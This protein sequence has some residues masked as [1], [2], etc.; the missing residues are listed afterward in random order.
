[1]KL[2]VESVSISVE[3]D[4]PSGRALPVIMINMGGKERKAFDMTVQNWSSMVMYFPIIRKNF[5]YYFSQLQATAYT[6]MMV[7]YYSIVRDCWE[8]ILEPVMDPKDDEAPPVMWFMN[9]SVSK[10]VIKQ[11]VCFTE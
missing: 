2:L 7:S 1:M 6:S 4:M 3:Q 5:K 8:P 11:L 9:I 10:E